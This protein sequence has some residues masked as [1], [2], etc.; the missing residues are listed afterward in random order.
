MAFLLPASI[1]NRRRQRPKE[2]SF[3][4]SVL[5]ENT[6]HPSGAS[7]KIGKGATETWLS[8]TYATKDAESRKWDALISELVGPPRI[9]QPASNPTKSFRS[10]P[11]VCQFGS[12]DYL[13]SIKLS[14]TK[15]YSLLHFCYLSECRRRRRRRCLDELTKRAVFCYGSQED[16][17]MVRVQSE[18]AKQT[19]KKKKSSH[20]EI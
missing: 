2:P 16:G 9:S 1:P 8:R 20:L 7:P 12:G 13:F 5:T 14:L 15:R 6:W 11:S 4:L 19:N 17:W 10:D 3:P 18:Y